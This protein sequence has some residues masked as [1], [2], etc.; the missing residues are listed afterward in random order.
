MRLPGVN[1]DFTGR[2]PDLGAHEVGRPVPG[3]P[4]NVVQLEDPGRDVDAVAVGRAGRLID[5]HQ[6]ALC[7]LHSGLLT[8]G[9]MR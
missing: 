1:D 7:G 5:L 3:Y 8:P 2:A 9:S 6:V 4:C